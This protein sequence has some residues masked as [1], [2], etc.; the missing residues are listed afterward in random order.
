MET[1]KAS[2]GCSERAKGRWE[3]LRQAVLKQANEEDAENNAASMHHF[4]GYQMIP[5]TV[6]H[7]RLTSSKLN[8][9]LRT[10]RSMD[11]LDVSVPI[12]RAL[13]GHGHLVNV[14]KKEPLVVDLRV[15]TL[16]LDKVQEYLVSKLECAVVA[17]NRAEKTLFVRL[18]QAAKQPSH[19]IQQYKLDDLP[20]DACYLLIHEKRSR[21]LSSLQD[22]VCHRQTGIDNTGDICI[23]D[24]SITLAWALLQENSEALTP[25]GCKTMTV[26]ELGAGMAGIGGL[27]LLRKLQSG[28]I[29]TQLHLT[30]GQ[31]SAVRNNR[32]HCRCMGLKD[33]VVHC[34]VLQWTTEPTIPS[35]ASDVTLIA[36]CT[37]FTKY[38][39][40]LFWS[41][42]Y[43]TKVGGT[44]WLC[45]PDR[46][47]T[48]ERFQ[49]LVEHVNNRASPLLH[50]EEKHY[51]ELDRKHEFFVESGDPS[52]SSDLH[53]PRVFV[54]TKLRPEETSDKAAALEFAM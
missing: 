14:G 3:L 28:N 30:D 38:H 29:P 15:P 31:E 48:R 35:L 53:R 26:L 1:I 52:Y 21:S 33:S 9:N 2:G 7:Q 46:A 47:G 45:Q 50:G 49:K 17:S 24:A 25:Q 44:I 39:A 4:A 27:S 5:R 11:D 32:L 18:P 19:W 51:A 43:H 34:N 6:L 54:L 37:H 22:L 23:W 36:D 8:E 13:H 42:V 16:P 10:I 40:E 20:D 12:L 41:A